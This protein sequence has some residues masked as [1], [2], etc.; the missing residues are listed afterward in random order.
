[1]RFLLIIL[2]IYILYRLV[3]KNIIKR[4]IKSKME[5]FTQQFAEND[6]SSERGKPYT[7]GTVT[8]DHA[9]TRDD[10]DGKLDGGEYVDFEEI[11]D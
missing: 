10:E 8:I 7:E 2:L 4:M 1:M 11:K 6:L 5:Q 9:P 3:I